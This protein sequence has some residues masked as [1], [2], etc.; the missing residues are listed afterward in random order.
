MTTPLLILELFNALQKIGTVSM[1]TS[2]GKVIE[3]HGQKF[4]V[5]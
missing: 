3:H 4:C 2:S 5:T 1:I